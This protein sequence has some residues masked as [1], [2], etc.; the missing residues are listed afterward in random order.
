M[1]PP[2]GDTKLSKETESLGKNNTTQ[3]CLDKSLIV[4]PRDIEILG[5]CPVGTV[6]PHTEKVPP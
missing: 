6:L 5:W 4:Y 3:K 1:G 2:H